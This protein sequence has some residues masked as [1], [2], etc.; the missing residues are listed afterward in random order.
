MA[1]GYEYKDKIEEMSDEELRR[2]QEE[3]RDREFPEIRAV[4][5]VYDTGGEV[6]YE[7]DELT[8]VC[9]MTGLPD[10]YNVRITYVPAEKMPELKSL[11]YYFLAYRDVPILHEHLAQ[12]V[13]ED[14]LGAIEPDELRVQLDV[15]VRGGIHATVSVE[16]E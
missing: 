3:I 10:F 9:P 1:D 6:S 4:D 5:Y 7:T 8:A 13:Y 14:F 11:K 12:K 16:S 2:Q 15:G